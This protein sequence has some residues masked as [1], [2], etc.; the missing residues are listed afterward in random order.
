MIKNTCLGICNSVVD[1]G[2][3]N[4]TGSGALK[5]EVNMKNVTNRNAKSTIGVISNAGVERG[6]L[7]FGIFFYLILTNAF[8]K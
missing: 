5:L 1:D 8:I 6:I 7:I 3:S 2:G 4:I